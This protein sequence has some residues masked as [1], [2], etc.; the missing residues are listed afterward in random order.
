[1]YL[2]LDGGAAYGVKIGPLCLVASPF[3]HPERRVRIA[4]DTE[5]TFV[6]SLSS[7]GLSRTVCLGGLLY[8]A[9]GVIGQ[10]VCRAG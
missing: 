9:V 10:V 2:Y 8:L 5:S 1:M 4:A 7:R 6:P 3:R